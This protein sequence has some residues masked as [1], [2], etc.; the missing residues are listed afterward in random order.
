MLSIIQ[1]TV[2]SIALCWGNKIKNDYYLMANFRRLFISSI[3]LVASKQ[4]DTHTHFQS[5]TA[6]LKRA[7]LREEILM[8]MYEKRNMY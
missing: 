7:H 8:E 5:N 6:Q 4:K 1:P 3:I 2:S